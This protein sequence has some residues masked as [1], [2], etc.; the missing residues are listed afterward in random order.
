[1]SSKS[2]DQG[3]AYEYICL[4]SLYEA[5][6]S[7]RKAKIVQNS[8][9]DAALRAWNT[10]DAYTQ[11]L[12]TLSA[13]STIDTIFALEPNIIEEG[14]DTL[15]LYIQTDSH[16]KEGDVR[17]IIIERRD[18][19]WEIGLSIKHN[20]E[21]VKHSRLSRR[22]DFGDK[23]YG[24]KCSNDYW[25]AVKPI[26]EYLQ[27]EKKKNTK[28]EEIDIRKLVYI[29]LLTAFKDEIVRH[30][31][32]DPS[33]AQKMVKYLL[34]KYDFY[35][36]ISVDKLR[37]TTIQSFNMFGTLNLPSKTSKPSIAVPIINLP[38]QLIHIGFKP[39]SETTLLMCFDNGWQFS[40]RIHNAEKYVCTS[41]KFD[42]QIAGMPPEI[43]IKYNCK[44]DQ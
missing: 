1:M 32:E 25:D 6:K 8:S 24:H 28:F 44:W 13:K 31:N 22:L 42:V 33:I 21:A 40:F 17:D 36:I 27:S 3:R 29:P 37:I 14:V 15:C 38:T 39:N 11:S 20:H 12:Y 10:L 9:F 2:N 41:L 5:I 30:V 18:I 16:G 35:K 4:T 7:I 34:S 43:N 19:V 23:W 26:F